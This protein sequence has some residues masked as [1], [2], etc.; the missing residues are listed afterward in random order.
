MLKLVHDR[1]LPNAVVLL[2]DHGD[3]GSTIEQIAPFIKGR[4]SIDGK[5]TAY[6]C[7]NYAC[8]TPINEID[9]I[10]KMLTA[11]SQGNELISMVEF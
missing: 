6:V 2:H 3:A 4:T 5:A 1:F 11:V 10:N 8:K 7:E 9:E